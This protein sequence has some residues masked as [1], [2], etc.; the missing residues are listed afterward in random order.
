MSNFFA[1]PKFA[2]LIYRNHFGLLK[3]L[4]KFDALQFY[5]ALGFVMFLVKFSHYQFLFSST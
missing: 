1:K 5:L 3:L 4:A 2:I